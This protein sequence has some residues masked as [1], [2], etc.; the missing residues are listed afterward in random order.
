MSPSWM[1]QAARVRVISWRKATAA[2]GFM[3][4]ASYAAGV[5]QGPGT[6]SAPL[7]PTEPL[8][9][10]IP[11]DSK[12]GTMR[13][14]NSEVELPTEVVWRPI[15]GSAPRSMT[16]A[17]LAT[18]AMRRMNR[19]KMEHRDESQDVDGADEG[20]IASS[21]LK[22]VFNADPGTPSS[23]ISAMTRVATYLKTQFDDSLT[24]KVTVGFDH[25][26]PGVLGATST[27]YQEVSWANS[28]NAL[29]D[30]M[31]SNDTIQNYLP[32]GST[33]PVRYNGSST[34][35]T[36]ETRVFWTRANYRAAVGNVSGTVA[37]IVFNDNFQWDWN[38]SNGVNGISF[39]DVLIHEI[40]HVL[41]FT[42]GTDFRVNDI[43]T[44]DI[45]R[46]QR[47]DN[48]HDY[49]P[50]STSDF[51]KRPRLASFNNPNDEQI[52]DIVSKEY[53]MSDGDPYQASHFR[54]QNSNIGL[55]DPALAPGETHYPNFYS[56]ADLKMLDAIGWDR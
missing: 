49:N 36:N 21:G 17:E 5:G 24:I 56:S 1:V 14:N 34:S 2:L 30:D 33:I 7:G 50:D 11:Q 44:L 12:P 42:S 46:F 55:M 20:G 32:S 8:Y 16:R 9:V 37:D 13:W 23:A 4:A 29:Q 52:V 19:L 27:P 48:G 51:K 35:I 26:A 47:T 41:G 39:E 15:C 45:F 3:L 25:M 43:E 53:R 38:P 31:D 54:E 6:A 22:V 28:R 40:G 18:F 10:I